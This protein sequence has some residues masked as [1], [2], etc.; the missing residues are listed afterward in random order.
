MRGR[1]LGHGV[2][3]VKGNGRRRRQ[4]GIVGWI[5]R[6]GRDGMRECGWCSEQGW[7]GVVQLMV[8]TTLVLLCTRPPVAAL[9]KVG[10][11]L[12]P[13]PAITII[14]REVLA[15]VRCV[16]EGGWE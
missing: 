13:V 6:N 10:P 4:S 2:E 14:G 3:R 5:G 1:E 16:E 9:A 12:L 7:W 11:W 8:A 15:G